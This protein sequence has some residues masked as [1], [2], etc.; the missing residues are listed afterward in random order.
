[1]GV[2]VA[3]VEALLVVLQ[4]LPEDVGD[5][6]M[7]REEMVLQDRAG[8]QGDFEG[9]FA[10]KKAR[11]GFGSVDRVELLEHAGAPFGGDTQAFAVIEGER[12]FVLD[13]AQATGVEVAVG[14]AAD[15]FFTG[16]I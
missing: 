13:A 15:E 5:E 6:R 12:E 4:G 9:E 1:M 10:E 2:A 14:C 3:L 7:G 8:R 16:F 11:Q